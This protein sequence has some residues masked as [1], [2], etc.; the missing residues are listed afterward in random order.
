MGET[1]FRPFALPRW[2]RVL[3]AQG[4]LGA[5][6]GTSSCPQ[7]SHPHQT[8]GVPT[9]GSGQLVEQ[10]L[11]FFQIGG[12]EPLGE[13]A[14]DRREEVGGFGTAALV[15]AQ[16][17]KAHGGAQFPEPCLL[18]L[19]DGQGFEIQALGR[20]GMPLPQQQLAFVPIQLRCEPAFGRG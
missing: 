20:V 17:G 7:S 9:A 6:A 8:M 19:G 5:R 16:P 18:L 14:V 4:D 11:R 2:N 3:D 13:P 10:P 1:R 12:V 15:A